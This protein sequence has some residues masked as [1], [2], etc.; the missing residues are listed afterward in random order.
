MS[1]P[2]IN[3]TEFNTYKSPI[4]LEQ[5]TMELVNQLQKDIDAQTIQH[6]MNCVHRIKVDIDEDELM[7]ALKYDRDQY[8]EGFAAGRASALQH[9]HWVQQP[10]PDG[11]H[12]NCSICN[13]EVSVPTSEFI[14][15]RDYHCYLDNFCGHCGAQMDATE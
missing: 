3:I 6:I 8:I 2:D 13:H 15:P 14:D 1:N 11:R 12:F 7:R 9:G 10:A 5:S 4:S